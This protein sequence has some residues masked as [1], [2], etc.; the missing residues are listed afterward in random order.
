VS[1]STR[2]TLSFFSVAVKSGLPS[3]ER[4]SWIFVIFP[5]APIVFQ[6]SIAPSPFLSSSWIREPSLAAIWRVSITPSWSESSSW[7]TTSPPS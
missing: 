6:V 4:S 2:T 7:R 3:P 5:S 1:W